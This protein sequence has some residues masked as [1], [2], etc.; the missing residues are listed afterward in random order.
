MLLPTA[1]RPALSMPPKTGQPREFLIMI[2][3]PPK[4]GSGRRRRDHLVPSHPETQTQEREGTMA[5]TAVA[6]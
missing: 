2:P 4:A 6:L 5:R 3:M 1:A